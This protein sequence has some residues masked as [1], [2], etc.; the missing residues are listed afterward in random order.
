MTQYLSETVVRSVF[1]FLAQ[2]KPGSRL[3]F[4]YIVKDFLDGEQKY[5]LD[6]LYRLIVVRQGL[7]HFGL[8]P[9]QVA[10]FIGE[11][12]W[13]ELEQAGAAE[14]RQHYLL[15]HGRTESVMEIERMVYAKKDRP[16]AS[17]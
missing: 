1:E 5:G 9:S 11:Y 16:I 17:Q 13:K 8:P 14:Y 2:A 10:A 4:T 6:R 12:S 3:A 7:W 15:P